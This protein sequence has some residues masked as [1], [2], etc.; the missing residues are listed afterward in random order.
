L[1]I[2]CPDHGAVIIAAGQNAA[3]RRQVDHIDP[4]ERLWV[5]ETAVRFFLVHPVED[6]F[7]IVQ[8]MSLP[9]NYVQLRYNANALWAEVCSRQWDCPYCGNRPLTE[10]K[11]IRLSEMGFVGG[12]PHRNFE[13]HD[14]GRRPKDLARLLEKLLVS[15]F[16]EPSDFAVAVYPKRQDTLR[17]IMTAFSTRGRVDRSGRGRRRPAP[18]DAAG[19]VESNV[20]PSAAAPHVC[21]FCGRPATRRSTQEGIWWCG[22]GPCLLALDAAEW[23]GSSDE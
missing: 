12:G 13:S 17:F 9:C 23:T 18:S 21:Q 4:E 7:L 3:R 11:E 22:Q 20:P 8:S 14:V 19:L 16:D 5:I 10:E 6:D 1:V 15:T 2:N